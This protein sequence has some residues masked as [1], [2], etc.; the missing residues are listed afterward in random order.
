M[1][2]DEQQAAEMERKLEHLE[3]DIDHAKRVAPQGTGGTETATL[4]GVAGDVSD[5][6]GGQGMGDDPVGAQRRQSGERATRLQRLE[7]EA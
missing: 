7:R 2:R 3:Q 1:D 6:E 5:E 4:G